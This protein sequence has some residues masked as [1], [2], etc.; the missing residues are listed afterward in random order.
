MLT[1]YLLIALRLSQHEGGNQRVP[2]H[3]N[4]LF[5]QAIRLIKSHAQQ[6]VLGV[7]Q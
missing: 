3:E 2:R 6:D 7:H 5:G 1:R 4:R